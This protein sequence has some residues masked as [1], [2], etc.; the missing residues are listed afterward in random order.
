MR[1]FVYGSLSRFKWVNNLIYFSPLWIPLFCIVERFSSFD[2]YE[3]TIF[4]WCQIVIL[5]FIT[6]ILSDNCFIYFVFSISRGFG[7][8]IYKEP[9]AVDK[10]LAS[11][12]H[13]LDAKMVRLVVTQFYSSF[14]KSSFSGDHVQNTKIL[15]CLNSTVESWAWR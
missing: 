8:V 11:G 14:K 2:I 10:V 9:A 4:V 13:Q 15:H 3:V 6:H 5:Q 12:P 7:F 1:V